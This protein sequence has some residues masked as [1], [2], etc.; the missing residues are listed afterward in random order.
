MSVVS[1]TG[2]GRAEGVCGPTRWIWEARSV[3]G[4]GLD[5]RTRLPTGYEAL[6]APIREAAQKRFRRGSIQLSLNLRREERGEAAVINIAL[7]DELLKA[8]SR[9]INNDLVQRPRWDGMLQVRG[10]LSSPDAEEQSPEARAALD[11]AL[12]AGVEQA[13]D[14]LAATRAQEGTKTRAILGAQIARIAALTVEARTLAAAQGEAMVERIRT[15]VAAAAPEVLIDP[16]RLAQEAALLA[17]RAD[18]REELDRL[19]AHAEEAAALLAGG[20]AAGR[21]LDFLSQEFNREANTLC[22]KSSDL[23]LTR[24][25]LDLKTTIDQLREQAANVE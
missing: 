17:A 13:F 18:V 19:N 20:E 5:V 21:R 1:M 6:E 8:G 25:G 3:N 23:A 24:L 15:R 14:A 7:L 9:Y 16:Q 22:S 10:V 2:F 4:R 12:L 11:K